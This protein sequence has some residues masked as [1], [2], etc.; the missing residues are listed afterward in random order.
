MPGSDQVGEARVDT[1]ATRTQASERPAPR[2]ESTRASNRGPNPGLTST[3]AGSSR[4]GST[5]T[6]G[7]CEKKVKSARVVSIGHSARVEQKGDRVWIHNLPVHPPDPWANPIEIV[8]AD[9][10]SAT[11]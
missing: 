9:K 5:L 7:W 4:L 3:C 10:A 11:T 2:E 6:F 8:F 1:H